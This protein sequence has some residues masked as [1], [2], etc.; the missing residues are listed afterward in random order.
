MF[1]YPKLN[2]WFGGGY[3]VPPPA[4]GMVS[5]WA[6]EGLVTDMFINHKYNDE[7]FVYDKLES[8]FNYKLVYLLPKVEELVLRRHEESGEEKENT[9]SIIQQ[10]LA[11][12]HAEAAALGFKEKLPDVTQKPEALA[13]LKVIGAFYSE[14]YN[15]AS[16]IKEV[17]LAKRIKAFGGKKVYEKEKLNYFNTRL[18]EIVTSS[19][20][21]E[22]IVEYRGELVQMVDPIY[23]DPSEANKIASFDAHFLTASK[24][25]FGVSVSTYF[26]NILV[27]WLLNLS[28]FA[29]LYYDLFKKLLNIGSVVARIKSKF[30]PIKKNA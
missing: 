28:L 14:K 12:D 20:E 9:N 24:Y 18:D 2:S 30:I 21:K 3:H 26:F 7:K 23:R 5:R 10:T 1:S 17:F 25:L 19:F 22:K 8:K 15:D 29:M 27:I 13:Y 4:N 16:R 6:Y 11:K